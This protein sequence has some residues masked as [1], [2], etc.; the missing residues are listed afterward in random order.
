MSKQATHFQTLRSFPT[1]RADAL[2]AP[3]AVRPC[4][5]SPKT[6]RRIQS[7]RNKCDEGRR[8][9]RFQQQLVG[10]KTPL[11]TDPCVTHPNAQL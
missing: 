10:R 6:K 11:R 7:L 1:S 8:R 9:V 3:V 4:L 5:S 2:C